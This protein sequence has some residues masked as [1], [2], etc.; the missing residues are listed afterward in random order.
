MQTQMEITSQPEFQVALS[1]PAAEKPAHWNAALQFGFRF[2]FCYFVLYCFPFPVGALPYTEKPA[3]WYELG[4]HKAVPWVAQHWLH[5]AQPI[6]VFSNGSGDTTYDYVKVLCLLVLAVVATIV[7]SLLDRK[8]A[9]YARLHQWLR[10]Y[11]RLTLGATLLSYG[12]YKVIPSQFPGLAHSRYLETYGDS[13]PM[14]ILWAFMGASKSYTIFAGAVEMLGGILLF[15]PRLVTLGALIG[16]G[17]MTNVF[18]LNMS[19]DVPVK[20]YSF[21]LLALGVFLVFPEMKRLADF[22]VFNRTTQS[23]SSALQF[24]RSWLN[25]SFL[26]GQLAFGL[27]FAG[28]SLY[29]SY[30][31]VKSYTSEFSMKPPLAGVWVVDEFAVNGQPRLPLLTDAV[32]LQKVLFDFNT[33]LIIQGM[34]G[35]LLRLPA[36]I[37]FNKKT[38]ELTKRTDPKWKASLVYEL[39][40]SGTMIIDGQLGD[41]KVHFTL[42]HI[43]SDYLL[44]NRG[45]HWINEFPFNR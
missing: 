7:W 22:F 32:R 31:S 24:R 14:G 25:R 1:A 5:L 38:I 6:T 42:H 13:S 44:K 28:L 30:Q 11:V 19:Y 10:F 43:D 37:D 12:A 39:S 8:R 33:A 4:W 2:A 35:K 9:N 18:V 36:K 27:F 26:I 3:E 23:L 40:G 21:H 17:A 16:I 20:L 15:L 45:F 41:E 29:Q 34:D